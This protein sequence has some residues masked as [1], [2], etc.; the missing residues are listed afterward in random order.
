MSFSTIIIV[1][2]TNH[3]C[4]IKKKLF[5]NLACDK[6]THWLELVTFLT[7][8]LVLAMEASILLRKSLIFSSSKLLLLVLLATDIRFWFRLSS[9]LGLVREDWELSPG[10]CTSFAF[11]LWGISRNS[12]KNKLSEAHNLLALLICSIWVSIGWKKNCFSW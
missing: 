7:T 11:S 6:I 8:S 5:G 4:V 9:A 10:D 2:P 3:D 12:L 1:Q